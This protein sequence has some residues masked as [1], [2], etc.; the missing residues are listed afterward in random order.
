MT[1]ELSQSVRTFAGFLNNRA[2]NTCTFNMQCEARHA[3]RVAMRPKRSVGGDRRDGN[4][5]K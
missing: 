1:R 2:E 4:I 3:Y 5:L